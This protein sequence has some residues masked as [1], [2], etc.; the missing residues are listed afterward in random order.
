MEKVTENIQEKLK[1]TYD[2]IGQ[3]G[4]GGGGSVY[5][6]YHKRLQKEVV[7]KRMHMKSQNELK[8]RQEVNILKN[9]RNSY[10]PQVYD[11]LDTGDEVYTVIDFIPGES[12][13]QMLNKNV[14]F[15]KEKVVKY[16]R[17]LCEA[18]VYLH[19]Q[20]IP[21]LHGDIKPANIMLTPEDNVCLIDFNISGF[22]EQNEIMAIG[23]SKG[24]AA[25]EQKALVLE[26]QERLQKQA[27]ALKAEGGIAEGGNVPFR[28]SGIG[29]EENTQTLAVFA[30]GMAV[31]TETAGNMEDAAADLAL[32]WDGRDG[33]ETAFLDTT[34]DSIF[35][36]NPKQQIDAR[37]DIYS[38]GATLYHLLTGRRPA[39]GR[40]EPDVEELGELSSEAFAYI[41][42]TA[43]QYRKEDRFQSA[44]KMLEALDQIAKLDGRYKRLLWKQRVELLFSFAV[45]LAGIVLIFVGK[46]MSRTE[47]EEQYA[48]YISK[49][50]EAV[51]GYDEKMFE[52]N[53]AACLAMDS[54]D[55]RAHYERAVWMYRQ[56]DFEGCAGYIQ[57]LLEGTL[58]EDAVTLANLY[59]LL[60]NCYVETL[61]YGKAAEALETALEYDGDNTAVYR[62]LAIAYAG[63]GRSGEAKEVLDSAVGRGLAEDQIYL[64]Q[65]E[66]AESQGDIE[67]AGEMFRKCLALATD[68]SIR[69]RAYVFYCDLDK[70][71]TEALL[72]N[73]AMLEEAIRELPLGSNGLLYERLAQMYINLEANT[74][75][76]QYG[77]KAIQVFQD[78]INNGMA[79]YQ[80]YINLTILY[81]QAREFGHAHEMIDQALDLY[82]ENYVSYKRKAFLEADEQ[83]DKE[84]G[85]RDYHGFEDS[86]KRAAELYKQAGGEDS[87]M[88]LLEKIHEELVQAG[89]L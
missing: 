43:M 58:P 77:R 46:N 21:I 47:R 26:I 25:P 51:A 22:F 65:G 63:D 89:W 68:D 56:G 4:E 15:T 57:Q 87:E 34:M 39:D 8:N 70:N 80:T 71:S 52:E 53:Y 6:A 73:A 12:F 69:M 88:P 36:D 19:G 41:L 85:E 35:V 76:M 18:L 14:R 54:E 3:V 61:E 38:L 28:A 1:D 60:G 48:A 49:L 23:Y 62:D 83:A 55:P 67:A 81:E 37:S 45:I 29:E 20:D 17:Q 50:E 44:V 32:Q 27:A 13:Q 7:I 82:G 9:L 16:A 64:V 86:Y 66:I 2:I 59:L 24:Y 31:H 10:L 42:V 72:D 40:V 30:E 11:F 78:I 74:D 33:R 84:V 75:D 5:K 79:S